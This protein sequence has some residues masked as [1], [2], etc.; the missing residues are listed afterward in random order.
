MT[1]DHRSTSRFVL[2]VL[3]TCA[4]VSASFAAL[5]NVF[6][7][8]LEVERMASETACQGQGVACRGQMTRWERT[9]IGQTLEMSTPKGGKIVRCQ[10]EYV[11]FGAYRCS[12]RGEL[13]AQP[14]SS[15]PTRPPGT[16]IAASAEAPAVMP[17][18]VGAGKAPR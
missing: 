7:E 8:T 6:G 2:E 13:E 1:T 10:R 12:L 16:A 3:I 5:Y 4:I 9:P 14:P 15:T 18:R 11:L 17:V